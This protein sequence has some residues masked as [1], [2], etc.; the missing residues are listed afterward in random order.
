MDTE[1]IIERII[2]KTNLNRDEILKKIQEQIK[3]LEGLIDED[4][5]CVMLAKNYGIELD[6]NQ[7][8]ARMEQDQL[9][10][11]LKPRINANVVGRILEIGSVKTFSRTDGTQGT[12][13]RFVL[14][15]N[16]GSISCIVWGEPNIDVLKDQGFTKGEI[17]RIVNGLTKE[18]TTRRMEIHI[19]SRSRIQ[20]NPDQVD[21]KLKQSKL[22]SHPKLTPLTDLKLV[23]SLVSVQGNI[24]TVYPA[25]NFSRKDRS[26]GKRASLLIQEGTAQ[27][28]IT[29]W[30]TQVDKITNLKEN[31]KIII[32]Q[33]LTKPN[34]RDNSKIDLTATEFTEIQILSH[35]S[36]EGEKLTDGLPQE[37]SENISSPLRSIKNLSESGGYASIEGIIQEIDNVQQVTRKDGTQIAKLEFI[38]ADETGAI[39]AIL[40][41]D[42]TQD[43]FKKNDTIRL[44]N[45]SARWSDYLK[46][47]QV[48]LSRNGKIEH[49][50][51]NI[52]SNYTLPL[53]VSRK[54]NFL[55][56][57]SSFKP[58]KII[59][60]EHDDG[61]EFKATITKE[62]S[63]ITLYKA[64][65]K[66]NKKI[67]NCTCNPKG[68]EVD[69]VI[70][71]LILE[72]DSGSIRGSLI[73][74]KA[75]KFLE[76]SASKLVKLEADGVLEETLRKK[77]KEIIGKEYKLQG[78]AKFSEYSNSYDVNLN[79]FSEIDPIFEVEKIL[80]DI[81]KK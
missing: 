61:F 2:E 72:D 74:E 27:T 37:K 53:N 77:S 25:K 35:S 78:R 6:S 60:I 7:E 71:N 14:E 33:L 11:E 58:V 45:V 41:G 10:N 57:I 32:S 29:F 36:N 62:F 4:G 19:G 56:P 23:P 39:R 9:I 79:N 13:F 15:D 12:Y 81:D 5:A 63:R 48:T 43:Q 8:A 17:V 73:G 18:N 80:S 20:T 64:C 44:I 21:G 76:L 65:E 68:K 50:D 24:I 70:L 55:E 40:W 66:C 47:N 54:A 31:S 75:E 26:T 28:Y 69:R 34:F 42:Q 38:L 52:T 67:S 22:I 30:D 1:E 59:E 49:I 3:D 46:E 16:S 51:K